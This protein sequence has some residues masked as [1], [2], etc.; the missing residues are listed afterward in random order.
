MPSVWERFWMGCWFEFSENHGIPVVTEYHVRA[1][2][3]GIVLAASGLRSESHRTVPV[4]SRP[5]SMQHLPFNKSCSV[6]C[7]CTT[8]NTL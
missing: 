8:Q 2:K 4:T 7:A 6:F 3:F 5:L 1:N